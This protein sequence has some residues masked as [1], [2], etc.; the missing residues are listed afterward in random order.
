MSPRHRRSRDGRASRN[1]ENGLIGAPTGSGKTLAAFQ[2]ALDALLQKGRRP[3]SAT[4][5]NAQPVGEAAEAAEQET[6]AIQHE[7][8]TPELE[9]EEDR[10]A[11]QR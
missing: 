4:H 3:R 1:G 10:A 5:A 7:P 11:D 8:L 6:V 2:H 9:A